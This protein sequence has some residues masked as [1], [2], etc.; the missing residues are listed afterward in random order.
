MA[1]SLAACD[2]PSAVMLPAIKQ[3]N[4]DACR[5]VADPFRLIHTSLPPLPQYR[6]PEVERSRW[7]EDLV[8]ERS[9]FHVISSGFARLRNN[10]DGCHPVQ[11]TIAAKYEG[12]M[13]PKP[14]YQDI[15]VFQTSVTNTCR[16]VPR[17]STCE[18]FP[19]NDPQR[20]R[21]GGNFT[22]S[23][24]TRRALTEY[25]KHLYLTTSYNSMYDDPSTFMK[26]KM[27]RDAQ[28]QQVCSAH[29][30][31]TPTCCRV[32]NHPDP[33]HHC[34]V[35]GI[36]NQSEP[37]I[38]YF[39]SQIF[40]RVS[41]GCNAEHENLSSICKRCNSRYCS[42]KDICLRPDFNQDGSVA[43]IP[44]EGS[45]T[46]KIEPSR[47]DTDAKRE[48]DECHTSKENT[49]ENPKSKPEVFGPW[50]DSSKMAN[51]EEKLLLPHVYRFKLPSSLHSFP[52]EKR[53]DICNEGKN[54]QVEKADIKDT[55]LINSVKA[56]NRDK[57]LQNRFVALGE[58]R[59]T[60]TASCS[61]SNLVTLNHTSRNTWTFRD[62]NNLRMP[63]ISSVLGCTSKSDVHKRYHQIHPDPIPDLRDF[64]R[65]SKRV[66]FCGYNSSVFR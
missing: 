19:R 37:K 40:D 38:M 14:L 23:A 22:L 50:S 60:D 31:E 54:A 57:C 32:L 28:Y 13:F 58:S 59:R 42:Q 33:C 36:H 30:D 17:D 4:V 9:G 53:T 5:G 12:Y 8:I 63:C 34:W 10:Y 21:D 26:E 20:Q 66:M 65:S 24:P 46:Q 62:E 44:Q 39:R 43:D 48:D 11:E 41:L 7:G 2:G 18:L 29:L 56:L 45:N 51:E 52:Q 25:N 49:T 47:S 1:V 27:Q 15:S 55:N 61:V 64:Q 3:T 35:G 16:S 6:L